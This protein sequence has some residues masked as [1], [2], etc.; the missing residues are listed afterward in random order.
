MEKRK[1]CKKNSSI[2][3][4]MLGLLVVLLFGCAKSAD[5]ATLAKYKGYTYTTVVQGSYGREKTT[6]YRRKGNGKRQK[7]VTFTGAVQR[8]GYGYDNKLYYMREW[9]A[10]VPRPNAIECLDLRTKRRSTIKRDVY[11]IAQRGRYVI[12]VSS[13]EIP[14]TM[15]VINVKTKKARIISRKAVFAGTI[16]SGGLIYYAENINNGGWG[17]KTIRVYSCKA[18]GTGK[19]VVV[20]NIRKV[21]RVI[22]ITNRSIVYSRYTNGQERKYRYYW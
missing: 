14:S 1:I 22:S 8:A 16:A 19:R 20:R 21:A 6:I 2:F 12:G 10:S 11:L 13:P 18:N 3:L 15:Y 9:A 7:V 5:A 17:K 4:M